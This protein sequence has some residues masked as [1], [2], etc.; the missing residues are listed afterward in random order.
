MVYINY[1][2]CTNSTNSGCKVTIYISQAY[3]TRKVIQS[4][5]TMLCFPRGKG[6]L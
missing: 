3:L 6:I 4:R 5:Q 1:I 2:N